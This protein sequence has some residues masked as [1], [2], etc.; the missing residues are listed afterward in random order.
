MLTASLKTESSPLSYRADPYTLSQPF[1]T[2]KLNAA[3]GLMITASHNP[4]ADNG[5]KVR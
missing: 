4:A 2:T 3:L 5:Y 1:A